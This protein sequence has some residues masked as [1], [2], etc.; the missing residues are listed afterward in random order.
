MAQVTTWTNLV[1][2][3]QV[4]EAERVDAV[5][6]HLSAVM[7]ATEMTANAVGF[8]DQTGRKVEVTVPVDDDPSA[9]S[10]IGA[11]TPMALAALKATGCAVVSLSYR[12]EMVG[13]GELVPLAG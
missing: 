10:V 1:L 2:T 6:D 8:G 13:D 9:L 3:L 7:F 11:L 12:F 4:P 5:L